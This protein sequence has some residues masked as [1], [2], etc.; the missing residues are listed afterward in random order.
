MRRSASEYSQWRKALSHQ[1]GTMATLKREM[2]RAYD[3]IV[4]FYAL[5]EEFVSQEKD[6]AD[7]HKG[8]GVYEILEEIAGELKDCTFFI[9]ENESMSERGVRM[10]SRWIND[11]ISH[12]KIASKEW[13]KGIWSAE[14]YRVAG[15]ILARWQRL[16]DWA[17][18]VLISNGYR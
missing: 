13:K 16:M 4:N 2:P 8:Y 12:M 7:Y 14:G 3:H 5:L 9:K 10:E 11:W 17:K 1:S 15:S 18:V 6:F